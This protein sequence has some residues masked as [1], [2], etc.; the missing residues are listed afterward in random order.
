MKFKNEITQGNYYKKR[1]EKAFA[2]G[3]F[4]KAAAH[5]VKGLSAYPFLTV[6]RYAK[7]CL[8]H[9]SNPQLA[10]LLNNIDEYKKSFAH[11]KAQSVI[12]Q[13]GK[14]QIYD[15]KSLFYKYPIYKYPEAVAEIQTALGQHFMSKSYHDLQGF[16]LSLGKYN[17]NDVNLKPLVLA[18]LDRLADN[19]YVENAIFDFMEM[20]RNFDLLIED[21]LPEYVNQLNSIIVGSPQY[22]QRRFSI[23]AITTIGEKRFD[24]V[25]DGL[26]LLLKNIKYPETIEVNPAIMVSNPKTWILD[27]SIDAVGTLALS[28][29][30]E[31]E[32]FIP[33]IVSGLLKGNQYTQK[34]SFQALINFQEGGVDISKYLPR[35][36]MEQFRPL[37][38]S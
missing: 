16:F 8:K 10:D 12:E 21:R 37:L 27:A 20:V 15:F 34:K 26:P 30:C 22:N 11:V 33:D 18:V 19:E 28:H 36:Q 25:Q 2:N 13:I 7:S 17:P 38:L 31:L 32:Y 23:F 14:L 5:Y 3:Q 6:I 24:L 1:G 35:K 9:V 29:A 4:K